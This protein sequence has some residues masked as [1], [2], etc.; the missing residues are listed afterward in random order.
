MPHFSPKARLIWDVGWRRSARSSRLSDD[1]VAYPSL[2]CADLK[3][4]RF[5]RCASRN[6][7]MHKRCGPLLNTVL[8]DKPEIVRG[9]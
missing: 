8:Y 3:A 4:R 6:Q 5:S 9:D 2:L 1:A 7:L